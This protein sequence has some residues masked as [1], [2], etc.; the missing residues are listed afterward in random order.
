MVV[1]RSPLRPDK[2]MVDK[3]HRKGA[4]HVRAHKAYRQMMGAAR[5]RIIERQ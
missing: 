5:A 4:S 3:A 1:K 2:A